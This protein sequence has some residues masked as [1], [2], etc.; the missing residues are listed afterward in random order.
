MTDRLKRLWRLQ[1]ESVRLLLIIGAVFVVGGGVWISRFPRTVEYELLFGGRTFS[2]RELTNM[3]AAWAKAEEC[4]GYELDGNRVRIPR[5]LRAKFVAALAETNAL[6]VEFDWEIPEDQENI[7]PFESLAQ[8]QARMQRAR[9]RELANIL[10]S[11]AGIEHAAVKFDEE[12][13]GGPR[14]EKNVTAM[15]A[16]RPKA[17]APLDPSDIHSI[18]HLVAATKAGLEPHK[19]TITDLIAGKTYTGDAVSDSSLQHSSEIAFLEGQWRQKIARALDYIRGVQVAVSIHMRPDTTFSVTDRPH[20]SDPQQRPTQPPMA[21]PET[22]GSISVSLAIPDTCWQSIASQSTP[23]LTSDT[24]AGLAASQT[25]DEVKANVRQH[26]TNLLSSWSQAHVTVST[27][28]VAP[29][30]TC[31]AAP[32]ALEGPHPIFYIAFAAVG[33]AVGLLIFHTWSDISA[34][35]RSAAPVQSA[36]AHT[37]GPVVV[38]Q[39]LHD[40]AMRDQ[41]PSSVWRYRLTET[42]RRNPKA[43]AS[44]L[45]TWLSRAG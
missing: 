2:E 24:R 17:G 26:V 6:P 1:S 5:A 18:R 23:E 12:V 27:Y 37:V 21:V 30:D 16:V 44:V 7:N 13:G 32:P 45:Q 36:A 22:A 40:E 14:R 11:M 33:L 19:V 10:G 43:A 15:V 25:L 42:V 3:E 35:R 4:D 34:L 9:E 31:A 28:S 29:N 39:P 38:Q 41:E 20:S 8:K